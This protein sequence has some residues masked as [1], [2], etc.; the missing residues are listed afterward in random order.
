[1]RKD[2]LSITYR[3][4]SRTEREKSR[5]CWIEALI[6]PIPFPYSLGVGFFWCCMYA[7]AWIAGIP[8]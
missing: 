4:T 5:T 7:V 2:T 1:M 6:L 3:A 8:R